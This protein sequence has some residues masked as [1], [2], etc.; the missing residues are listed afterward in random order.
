M[1]DK[2]QEQFKLVL[3]TLHLIAAFIWGHLLGDYFPR[4]EENA[5]LGVNEV[6]EAVIIEEEIKQNFSEEDFSCENE[7]DCVVFDS[8]QCGKENETWV[9]S[10]NKAYSEKY[11]EITGCNT[12]DNADNYS[13]SCSSNTCSIKEDITYSRIDFNLDGEQNIYDYAIF[14][15]EFKTCRNISCESFI[16]DLDEDNNVSFHDYELF[17]KYLLNE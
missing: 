9:F 7:S 4:I 14:L 8:K 6:K 3:M 11:E 13:V 17:M 2:S 12:L 5:V 10:V 15:E 16:T 1:I